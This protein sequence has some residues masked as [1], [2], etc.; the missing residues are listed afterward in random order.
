MHHNNLRGQKEYLNIWPIAIRIKNYYLFYV[1][2]I[3]VQG[4]GLNYVHK[5]KQT[6]LSGSNTEVVK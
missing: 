6:I 4:M 1:H 5:I 2:Y 3:H